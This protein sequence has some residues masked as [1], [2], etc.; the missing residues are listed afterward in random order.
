MKKLTIFLTTFLMTTYLFGQTN[1]TPVSVPINYTFSDLPTNQTAYPAGMVGWAVGNMTT[2]ANAQNSS[3]TGDYGTLT[4][5][6]TLTSAGVYN[7]VNKIGPL[8]TGSAS[9]QVVLAV[10]TTG[11]SGISV[12]YDVVKTRENT[13]SN[14]VTLQ[15]RVGNTG[16]WTTVPN[17][18]YES[19]NSAV[20]TAQS[21]NNLTLGADAD[22]QPNVQIRWIY[23]ELGGSGSRDGLGYTNIKVDQFTADGSGSLTVDQNRTL[24]NEIKDYQFVFKPTEEGLTAIKFIIPAEFEIDENTIDSEFDFVQ[25]ENEFTL[26]TDFSTIDSV[27]FTL[28]NLTRTDLANDSTFM[29]TWQIWSK[30]TGDFVKLNNLPKTLFIGSPTTINVV[31]GNSATGVVLRTGQY[32]LVRGIVTVGNELGSPS[33]IQD[34]TG[35]L[36]IFGTEFSKQVSIGDEIIVLGE[37]GSF[38][39]LTELLFPELMEK[40]SVGNTVEPLEVTLKDLADDGVG[41]VEVYEGMLVRV[42]KVT[43]NTATWAVT[44][45]GTNYILSDGSGKTVEIRIDTDAISIK[46]TPAPSGQFDVIGT[47]GQFKNASPFIGGYQ[48]LPRFAADI[49]TGTVRLTT[50]PKESDITPESVTLYWETEQKANSIVKYGLTRNLELG[51]VTHEFD[52]TKHE[53]LIGGNASPLSASTVYYMQPM[54]FIGTDTTKGQVLM[55]ITGSYSTGK[56]NVYFNKSVDHN[57]AVGELAHQNIAFS[58]TLVKRINQAKFSID[59]SMYSM[60]GTVGNKVATALIAAKNRGVAVRVIMETD[61]SNTFPPGELKNNLVPFITDNYGNNSGDGLMHNKFMSIDAHSANP[62]D[63]W[64]WTGSFNTTDPG[65][66]NDFQNVVEIQDQSLAKIYKMEFDE[67]WGSEGA[68]PN[69]TQSR[70][71]ANKLDNTPHRVIANGTLVEIYFSPSDRVTSHIRDAILTANH[72]A[73]VGLLSFTHS[74]LGNALKTVST[75]GVTVKSIIEQKDQT[76]QKDFIGTFGESF[77]HELSGLFH[78]KYVIIDHQQE[79]SHPIVV[80]GSHNWS[81]NAEQ[82]NNENTLII[83]SYR[84]AN[85]FVQE[86]A[87]RYTEVGGTGSIPT[88]IES[89]IL[90]TSF[91]VLGNYPNPFNPVTQIKFSMPSDGLINF[92]VYN[93]LGQKVRAF[94][95]RNYSAGIHSIEFSGH[96]LSSGL[97]IYSISNGQKIV[98]GKFI[99]SK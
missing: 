51:T 18:D 94:S 2:K 67:M 61:N 62:N 26:E 96:G 57:Y 84:V 65:E 10:N 14:G 82:R 68:T 89:D 4:T 98:T 15:Y 81:N 16:A 70:F 53:L 46:G 88:H 30:A 19:G 93:V 85:L 40:I 28:K 69:A 75:N 86:F 32:A 25:V 87:K 97:Y 83:H 3:P 7:W 37:I 27:V 73:Y 43:V 47:V 72:Q 76:S 12:S 74:E 29:E 45:S 36:N 71:G 60:S 42:N 49:I 8:G 39:G 1:P 20:N 34:A 44:G 33:V 52:T 31:R 92:D 24:R 58:D 22:N 11:K 50:V 95:N 9:P 63:S 17:S 91:E 90:P 35:G 64:L 5:N 55:V 6:T 99:L 38:N 80:T 54:S 66:N 41:G 23:Y 79:E 21:F 78:H 59:A 77:W 48:V 13:R 56:I